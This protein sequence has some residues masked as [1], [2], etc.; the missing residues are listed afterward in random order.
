[1]FLYCENL[2]S[3]FEFCS[4]DSKSVEDP[5]GPARLVLTPAYTRS[6]QA[7]GSGSILAIKRFSRYFYSLIHDSFSRNLLK[8]KQVMSFGPL[9]CEDQDKYS[10]LAAEE[11]TEAMNYY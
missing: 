2:D 6:R 10:P 7:E 5:A 3:F 9:E 4:M 11:E 8:L 1:M